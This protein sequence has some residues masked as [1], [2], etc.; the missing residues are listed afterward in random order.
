MRVRRVHSREL[1]KKL[2]VLADLAARATARAALRQVRAKLW[3][4]KAAPRGGLERAR[5]AFQC[6]VQTKH[7]L[8]LADRTRP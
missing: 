3:H 2:R 1:T 7:A 8:R 4:A 6:F 5:E